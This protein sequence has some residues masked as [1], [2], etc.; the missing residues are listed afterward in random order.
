MDYLKWQVFQYHFATQI[1]FNTTYLEKE[2]K[3][4][5]KEDRKEGKEDRKSTWCT[6]M[7]GK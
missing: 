2:K 7:N 6:Q 1:T 5:R 3:I 4:E